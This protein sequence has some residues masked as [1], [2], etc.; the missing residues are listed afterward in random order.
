[1]ETLPIACTLT[2]D[3]LADRRKAWLKV[4]TFSKGYAEVSGGL[5]FQFAPVAGIR[6]S[7]EELL[8][9]EAECC[10]WMAFRLA[11]ANCT[12]TLRITAAGEGGERGVREAFAPLTTAVLLRTS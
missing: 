6:G 11:E 10:P 9:L 12:L 8:R 2:A 7:L 4:G 3:D 1:M 5:A